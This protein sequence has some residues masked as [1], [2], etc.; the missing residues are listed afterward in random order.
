MAK[1]VISINT[2]KPYKGGEGSTSTPKLYKADAFNSLVF[3]ENGLR[4]LKPYDLKKEYDRGHDAG[5]KNAQKSIDLVRQ[6]SFNAGLEAAYDLVRELV[7]MVDDG[8]ADKIQKIFGTSC[9]GVFRKYR[10][11]EIIQKMREY[12]THKEDDPYDFR[13]GDELVNGSG[14]KGVCKG[15]TDESD[16]FLI[17]IPEL[18]SV[19]TTTYRNWKKT[20]KSYPGFA[21]MMVQMKG[22][23]DGS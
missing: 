3:D 20:G 16:T 1:Y 8:G 13:I 10:I 9:L 17:F 5:W 18:N 19:G 12:K 4:K 11:N 21:E 7:K 22:E 2:E 14:V 15:Y 23:G 6:E